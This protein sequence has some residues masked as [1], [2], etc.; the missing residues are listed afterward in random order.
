M[1]ECVCVKGRGSILY[2]NVLECVRV[3]L[4]VCYSVLV[5]V[6]VLECIRGTGSRNKVEGRYFI[7][8]C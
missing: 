5:S 7:Q 4:C 3:C 8:L 2:I 6:C 1:S